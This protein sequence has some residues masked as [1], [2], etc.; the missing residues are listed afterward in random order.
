MRT[1]Y[2]DEAGY[3]GGNLLD[4]AQ[5]FLALSAVFIS[6]EDARALREEVFSGSKA[7]ELKHQLLTRRR[8]YHRGLLQ[9]QQTCLRDHNAVSYI[10]NKRFLCILKL[11][12]HCVEPSFYA[13]GLDF[14]QDGQHLALASLLYYTGPTFWGRE[15][16]Q[17][18]LELYQKA[19]AEK[20]DGT[21]AMFCSHARSLPLCDLSPC[22]QPI[23]TEDPA[24][25]AE[26]RDRSTSTNAAFSLLS[27]LVTQLEQRA[28]GPYEIVHD[29]SPAMKA[30]HEAL[31]SL[32]ECSER[33]EFR[34]SSVCTIRYPLDLKGIREGESAVEVGLQFADILAGGIVAAAKVLC[35]PP[36]SNTYMSKVLALYSDNNLMHLL[37]SLDF[38]K[39]GENFAGSQ[40][41]ATMD[42]I[43]RT[44]SKKW[45]AGK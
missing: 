33:R 14:Y 22:I 45:D 17:R 8:R 42:F 30:Y 26:L 2:I 34:I 6:E 4:P 11:L 5:P 18:L 1:A 36:T 32:M 35:G 13:R 27:G 12:N 44:M 9:V 16:F 21:I 23:A 43:A 31:R 25:L 24:F 20:T 39:T 15:S 7:R 38:S 19:C 37:P 10:A 40:A 28:R 3:T 41:N 29:T